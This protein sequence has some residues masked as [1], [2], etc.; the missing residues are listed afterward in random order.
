MKTAGRFR[1]VLKWGVHLAA[2]SL[3]PLLVLE[4]FSGYAIVEW[5][6]LETLIPRAT[7]F[8]LHMVLQPIAAAAVA[9]HGLTSVRRALRRHGRGGRVTDVLL[10]VLGGSFIVVAAMLSR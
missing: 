6:A 4:F 9:I 7:A 1:C 5:R 8:R 3:L 2:W 10:F